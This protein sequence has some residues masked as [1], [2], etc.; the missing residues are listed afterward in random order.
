MVLSFT[1]FLGSG[2]WPCQPA[3]P[4]IL[5]SQYPPNFFLGRGMLFL[6]KHW[7]IYSIQ[8]DDRFRTPNAPW[9]YSTH[10]IWS[11]RQSGKN[12]KT[13]AN[14]SLSP[15]HHLKNQLVWNFI[16]RSSTTSK[17]VSCYNT[18]K[19]RRSKVPGETK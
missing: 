18:S 17:R 19:I 15:R 8:C 13:R 14:S 4:C 3:F 6:I 5:V 11:R 9:K 10:T 12:S 1:L 2:L 16:L 7:L